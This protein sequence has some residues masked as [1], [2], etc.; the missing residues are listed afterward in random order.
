MKKIVIIGTTMPSSLLQVN[1]VASFR[2]NTDTDGYLSINPGGPTVQGY[3]NWWKPGNVR[4]GYL[5]Y[6]DG[7][8]ANNLSLTLEASASFII[9]GGNV[10]IGTTIP[11]SKLTVNGTIHTK[12]V[13]VDL[14]GWPDYVFKPKYNLPSLLE[15]KNYIDKNHHLPEMPSEQEVAQDDLNLGEM[16]KLL[17]KKVEELTLYLIEKDKAL[18]ELLKVNKQQDRRLR[19]LEQKITDTKR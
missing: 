7:S 18:K 12:E 15:V 13:K 2:S 8:S 5:G 19:K 16:N 14:V 11:D 3:I 17:V 1:G 9:N 4:V 6:H 10:G